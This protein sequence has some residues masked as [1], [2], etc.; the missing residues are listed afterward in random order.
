MGIKNLIKNHLIKKEDKKYETR[1]AQKRI[2]YT[3]W[4]ADREKLWQFAHRQESPKVD[5]VTVVFAE[6][7][8]SPRYEAMVSEYFAEHSLVQVLYADEDLMAA[9]GSLE[10][11]FF[12]PDWSPDRL[13]S[14]RYIG[15]FLAVRREHFEKVKSLYE[16][17]DAAAYET[18]FREKTGEIYHVND[19]EAAE[20]W[21]HH[22]LTIGFRKN[23]QGSCVEAPQSAVGHLSEVLFHAKDPKARESALETTPFLC[24]KKEQLLRDLYEKFVLSLDPGQPA[25]SVIVPS[26]DHPEL[27]RNCLESVKETVDLPCEVIVVDNGSSEE[28]KEKIV[29]LL[30]DMKANSD[31]TVNSRFH[32]I[33]NPMEFNF[34]KMC[35]LGAEKA[36]GKLLLFLNDDVVLQKNCVAEMAARSIRPYT[37]AV[38]IKLLYPDGKKIQH[39]GVSQIAMGPVH[40]LQTLPDDRE[41]YART[42]KV[43]ANFLAVT[44]ACLMVEKS[45]FEEVG[46]FYEDLAVAF[47]DVDLCYMLYEHGY[48]N[49]C[50][51]EVFAYHHESLSRGDDASV[52]KLKRLMQER[53]T[54]L[55]RHEALAFDPFYSIHLNIQGLD[56]RIV[57]GYETRDNMPLMPSELKTVSTLGEVR[58]D[59]CLMV[60][61]EDVQMGRIIGWSVVLGDDNAC[62]DKTLVL[63]K[64]GSGEY[65]LDSLQGHLRPDLAVNM[66]DQVNVELSGFWVNLER[67]ELPA[68]EYRIGILAENRVGR[69][70]LVNWSNRIFTAK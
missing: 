67:S 30:T 10:N 1:L 9:D 6:G 15:S 28:N 70:R 51:N 49:V 39:A 43:T 44:A 33:Y 25:V 54:L 4:V 45:K 5:F 41:Y 7:E 47:N 11:P 42:N 29:A 65:I 59:A 26:K 62:Y 22:C 18:I 23:Y 50:I 35:D 52:E 21:L 12:K 48:F 55:H 53:D 2:T 3:D 17:L 38:G 32:Y 31:G 66:P 56:V 64:I 40:K 60:T 46:G 24:K 8:F 14:H 16:K 61:V 37:G 19:P 13:E 63:Q 27:L 20:Q 58:E 36:Q 68:G 69:I 34:S 57:P